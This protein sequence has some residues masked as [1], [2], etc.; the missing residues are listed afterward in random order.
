MLQSKLF[1]KTLK[2]APKEAKIASHKLLLRGDFISQLASG[3]YSFLPL[4]YRI[5]RKIEEVVREEM[6]A[7]G[8][9]EVFLPSLQPK[10]IWQKTDRWD[11]M[12]PP[13]FKIKDRHKK[14]FVLG[15]THEE[16]I[17]DLLKGQVQSYK[18]LPV[19]LYQIQ[20]KFRNE[21][22]FAGGLL[23]A[24]EFVMKDLYSFHPDKKD[25]D[26]FFNKVLLAYDKIFKRC[27]LKA[28][29]SEA[30][31]GVFT[32]EKTYEFQVMSKEGEDK[33]IYCPKCN[34]ATNLEVTKIKAGQ[35]CP[36]CESKLVKANSIEVGHTFRLGTKY[37]KALNLYFRDKKGEKKPVVM[38]CYGIGLGRLMAAIVEINHDDKGIIW[39]KEVAPFD[40]H[41]LALS[42]SKKKFE[43]K[44]G[45]VS[46]KLY[47]DLERAGLEVLYDDRKDKTAGEKFAEADL[48]GIPIRIIVSEKTLKR[49]CVE[50]KKRKEEKTRL[51]K[52]NQIINYVK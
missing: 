39:P 36:K 5:H 4:G 49:G 6:N 43:R 20:T 26:K 32:K 33:I 3:I 24:R 9:Q 51:I 41:L 1:S 40:C 7:I 2:K 8:G 19:Y 28:I 23:R 12:D 11:H 14:E 10:E 38:G 15:P 46:E 50:I 44:I 31:G 34:W 52:L 21:M 25:L 45:K 47:Q 42:G 48:I 13:L 35:K 30:S 17:T 22:R 18:D 37:S 16:V 29:K 27:G